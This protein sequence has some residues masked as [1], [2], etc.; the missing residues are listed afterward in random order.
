MNSG[1]HENTTE[2]SRTAFPLPLL[3]ECHGMT[4]RVAIS[5]NENDDGPNRDGR[6]CGDHDGQ[7]HVRLVLKV[8][9]PGGWY[10]HREPEIRCIHAKPAHVTI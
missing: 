4:V 6:G 2:I 9:Q 1:G 7:T 10:L 3:W 8:F 5:T